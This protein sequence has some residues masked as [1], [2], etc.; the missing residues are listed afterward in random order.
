[1][2]DAA[3]IIRAIRSSPESTGDMLIRALMWLLRKKSFGLRSGDL[4]G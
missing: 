1:M 2:V 4:G 3:S